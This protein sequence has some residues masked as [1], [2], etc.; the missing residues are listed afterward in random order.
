MEL[1]YLRAHP[2]TIDRLLEHQRIRMTLVAQGAISTVWRLTLEDGTDLFAKAAA[3]APHPMAGGP[4]VDLFECE[5]WGLAWLARSG[6]VPVPAVVAATSE[7]LVLPW[8]EP[9]EPTP[10][11][12]AEFGRQLAAMHRFGAPTFGAERHGYI[13][14]LPLDNT[15][16]DN[17]AE[18]YVEQRLWPY[19]R[20]CADAEFLSPEQVALVEQAMK[21]LAARAGDPEPPAL[22]HGDLWSGNVHYSGGQAY[23]VDPAAHGGHRESDLAMLATF[24]TPY[25]TEIVGAYQEV[26]PLADGWRD[27]VGMHQLHLLLVNC[28]LFGARFADRIAAAARTV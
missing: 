24:D 4:I 11:A 8:L 7:H 27:R 26:H 9:S 22:V 13:G 1:D 10:A 21:R 25:L 2:E 3:G 20:Y 28:V 18:F 17:W 5:A 15:P 12:S 23:L 14:G 6:A 19:L 16:A